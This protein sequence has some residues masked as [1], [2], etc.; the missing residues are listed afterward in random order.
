MKY[1]FYCQLIS[2]YF[3]I[4]QEFQSILLDSLRQFIDVL[5]PINKY[6]LLSSLFLIKIFI[7]L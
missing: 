6:F 4:L 2:H 5:S 3:E 7:K 1:L